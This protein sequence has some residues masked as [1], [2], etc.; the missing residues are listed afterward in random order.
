V[1]NREVDW[2]GWAISAAKVLISLMFLWFLY[3]TFMHL[4]GGQG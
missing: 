3:A 4:V 1:R 2:H